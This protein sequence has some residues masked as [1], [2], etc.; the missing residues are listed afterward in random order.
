[1]KFVFFVKSRLIFNVFYCFTMFVY[2]HFTNFTG[3]QLENSYDQ[4]CEIFIWICIHL[5]IYS[6]QFQYVFIWIYIHL[7]VQRDFQT[8]A[9][10]SVIKTCI[11]SLV[12]KLSF[13]FLWKRFLNSE[14]SS[15]AKQVLRREQMIMKTPMHFRYKWLLCLCNG[16]KRILS[17]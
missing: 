7:N 17:L 1:M 4:Q 15:E 12:L 6:F 16:F 5:N 2:K 8:F 10:I 13:I 3:I 9:C 11:T 14:V